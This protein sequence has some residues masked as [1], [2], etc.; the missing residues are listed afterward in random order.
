LTHLLLSELIPPLSIR[1]QTRLIALLRDLKR[2]EVV[3]DWED[4][5]QM[6]TVLLRKGINA[7]GL[8]DL[9]I[10]QNAIRNGLPLLSRDKH[11][12]L[13]SLHLPLSLYGDQ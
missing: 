3:P 7:V 1:K 11:F 13:I 12:A 2:Y 9:M 5:I 6:Q 10:G 8:P 4:L